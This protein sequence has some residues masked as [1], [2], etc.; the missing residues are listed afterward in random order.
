MLPRSFA[1]G[2]LPSRPLGV[3]SSAGLSAAVSCSVRRHRRLQWTLWCGVGWE[4][5]YRSEILSP[6][7]KNE[8]STGPTTVRSTS[9]V[10][11][12]GK[13][14]LPFTEE[15]G[16]PARPLSPCVLEKAR[17]DL[18]EDEQGR[19]RALEELRTWIGRNRNI[20]TCRE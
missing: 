13:C 19:E 15:T 10:S 4:P 12:M 8:G 3:S 20:L 7:A 5:G 16:A 18:N 11:T 9:K 1:P 17:L 2:C 14:E 6:R